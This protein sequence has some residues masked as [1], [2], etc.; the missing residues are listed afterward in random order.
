MVSG[1]KG[2]TYLEKCAELGIETLEEAR[3]WF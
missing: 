1:L 3:T 2:K